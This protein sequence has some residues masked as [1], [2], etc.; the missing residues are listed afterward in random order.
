M[1]LAARDF[2]PLFSTGPGWDPQ[3]SGQAGVLSA[4]VARGVTACW[5]GHICGSLSTRPLWLVL[6]AQETIP[7]WAAPPDL[8][9]AWG[10]GGPWLPAASSPPRGLGA[11]LLSGHACVTHLFLTPHLRLGDPLSQGLWMLG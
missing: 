8:E 5:D 9:E 7:C 2:V 1:S 6:K 3:C 11:R 10:Q 4:L